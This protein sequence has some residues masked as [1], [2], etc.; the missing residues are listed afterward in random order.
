VENTADVES[1]AGLPETPCDPLALERQARFAVSIAVRRDPDGFTLARAGR[2]EVDRA[3]K[4]D[5]V[6]AGAGHARQ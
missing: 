5:E 6:V 1:R 4:L 2:S 3:V